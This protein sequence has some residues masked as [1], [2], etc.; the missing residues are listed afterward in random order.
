MSEAGKTAS[1]AAAA[2]AAHLGGDPALAERLYGEALAQDAKD[3]AAL[4]GLGVLRFEQ[5]RKGEAVELLGA[6][7]MRAPE[8]AGIR[9]N[10]AAALAAC[11]RFAEAAEEYRAALRIEPAAAADWSRLGSVLA[12][13]ERNEE[14]IAA[15]ETALARLSPDAAD[16]AALYRR[17]ARVQRHAGRTEAAIGSWQAA[18]ALAPGHAGLHFNLGNAHKSLGRNAEAEA[19]Y[20]QALAI[21]SGLFRV[22][23]NLGAL[24]RDEGRLEEAEAAFRAALAAEPGSADARR[25]LAIVL[26]DL[27]RSDD[28]LRILEPL[29]AAGAEERATLD[30]A[31]MLFQA[32][33]RHAEAL[34]VAERLLAIDPGA[35]GALGT[36]AL[37]L[38][39]ME[40]VEEALAAARAA[41]AA[42][43]DDANALNNA[44]V[45]LR[46]LGDVDAAID[47]FRRA[48]SLK[49]DFA[50]AHS[51]LGVALLAKE[52]LE[53]GWVEYEW[54]WH[55]RDFRRGLR[56]Y[57]TRRWH[58][59]PRPDATLL[60]Y[61]EQGFGDTLQFARLLAPAA[62]RV[63]RLLFETQPELL[64]VMEGL[65]G[66]SQIF[67]RG[68]PAPRFDLQI[69]I[70]SLP[71]ALGLSLDAIPGRVPYLRPKPEQVAFWAPRIET[72][73]HPRI[74][75]VWQGNPRHPN[76]RNR[77][78]ALSAL[79]PL[80]E[81]HEA[82]WVSLQKVGGADA[83]AA[84]GLTS[85][86]MD[87]TAELADFSD[88]AALCAHLDL[89]IAVD[90]SVAHL[91]GALGR[92]VHLLLPKVPDFRWL[93]G[94]ADSPWYPSMRLF[95]QK[96]YGI[97]TEPLIELEAA[98]AALLEKRR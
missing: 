22:Q 87:P 90:T 11:G 43:R 46:A 69:P 18:L 51:S 88:T 1:P 73:V 23:V 67:A 71:A 64:Q 75:L 28:A 81:R 27:N 13:L 74:G 80:I 39:G 65:P 53:E 54:R 78:I 55:T 14:A 42:A 19:A 17:L 24:L 83:I 68:G 95:R 45:V 76:D 77:S 47:C 25:N 94:R 70:L 85:R 40:R 60:V 26:H 5:G 35:G 36:R 21:D 31:A 93:I 50:D 34:G 58:G 92:P 4:Q 59:E 10:H 2:L 57:E 97:W 56:R 33:H 15:Y 79:A 20:R 32:L 9:R 12:E 96:R 49:P 72:L 63:D 61:A 82:G 16:R 3:A 66:P 84:L 89:V 7:A 98:L 37:A 86:I 62:A 48:V 38:L 29:L 41:Q 30:I 8:V 44:G 91:A 52:R 6:A